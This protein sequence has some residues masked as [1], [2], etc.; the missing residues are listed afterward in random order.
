MAMHI[1]E[2]MTQ[3]D[4]LIRCR[5]CGE[6]IEKG[7]DDPIENSEVELATVTSSRYA[8]SII[9]QIAIE[10]DF[11]PDAIVNGFMVY[12]K[13]KDGIREELT[14]RRRA[15]TRMYVVVKKTIRIGI[16]EVM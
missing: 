10:G 7:G 3:L 16:K 8:N 9:D 2:P 12:S 6:L 14:I 11:Q 13:T 4:D 5:T 1:H 15:E